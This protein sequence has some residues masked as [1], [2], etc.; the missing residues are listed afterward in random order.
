MLASA[1]TASSARRLTGCGT[2]GLT[3]FA[4]ATGRGGDRP[5]AFSIAITSPVCV[6]NSTRLLASTGPPI[7]TS[8]LRHQ[9]TRRTFHQ[10]RAPPRV[11]QHAI[12]V[13]L[14]LNRQRRSSLHHPQAA[15]KKRPLA[16]S[17]IRPLI[18]RNT[19]SLVAASPSFS[20]KRRHAP[21]RRMIGFEWFRAAR[22]HCDELPFLLSHQRTAA[23][24]CDSSPA[25]DTF[26]LIRLHDKR[27]PALFRRG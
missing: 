20:A 12:R 27:P 14:L 17:F 4:A 22:R 2:A 13:S 26:A 7:S 5:V 11:D 25:P 15:A 9:L 6:D 19:G 8:T 18:S 10:G 1:Q 3:Q 21:L 16:A 24:S 23:T